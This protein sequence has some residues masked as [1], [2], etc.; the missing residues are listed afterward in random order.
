MMQLKEFFRLPE[1]PWE[2]PVGLK[3]VVGAFALYFGGSFFSALFYKYLQSQKIFAHT[4]ALISWFNFTTSSL[5]LFLL[6]LFFLF[7]S[8]AIRNLLGRESFSWRDPWAAF[9]AFIIAFPTVL[10]LN[11]LLETITLAIFHLKE[12]PDQIAVQFLKSTFVNPTYFLLAIVTICIYAPLI[13]ETLFRGFLQS[14]IRKHLGSKQAIV[15]TSVCFSLFHF[16]ATQ[17]YGNIPIIGSL[18]ILSLFLGFLYEKQRSILASMC[19]HSLFNTVSLLSIYLF[20]GLTTT[21]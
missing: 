16:S 1:T 6:I 9:S 21:L 7:L 10:V 12:L 17:S 8:P 19:L 18:F 2:V 13:E 4:V 20:G 3:H 11:K 15:I 14:F 5:I